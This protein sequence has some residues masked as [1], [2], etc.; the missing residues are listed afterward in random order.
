[1]YDEPEYDDMI[2]QSEDNINM[3]DNNFF[4]NKENPLFS[5]DIDLFQSANSTSTMKP[6]Q[7]GLVTRLPIQVDHPFI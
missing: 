4:L 2:D 6:V 3:F 7:V 1:M 5:S